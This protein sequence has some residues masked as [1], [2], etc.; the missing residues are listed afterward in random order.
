MRKRLRV[1]ALLLAIPLAMGGVAGVV[2]ARGGDGLA[3]GL[4]ARAKIETSERGA[5][6]ADEALSA[7][8]AGAQILRLPVL[9]FGMLGAA[10]VLAAY[11]LAPAFRGRRRGRTAKKSA[12]PKAAALASAAE[13]DLSAPSAKESKRI[14]KQAAQ[15]EQ[16]QGAEAAGEF[17]LGRNLKEEAIEIFLRAELLGRAAEVRHD[18]NRF[19]EAADLYKKLGKEEHAGRIYAQLGRHEDAAKCY[20]AAG[21]F[22]VAGDMFER[23]GNHREAGKCYQK[24][25][26]HRHAAQAFLKSGADALAAESLLSAF[27]EEGGVAGAKSEQKAKEMRGIAKK[28]A[29]ILVKLERFDEAEAMLVRSEAFGPAAKIAFQTG[30]FKRAAE[31]FLRVGRGDLAAKALERLGD[32]VGAARALGEYLRDKGQEAEAVEHLRK[33]GEHAAAGDLYRKLGR[34][35]EAGVCYRDADDFPAAAEAFRAAEQLEPAAEAY[36]RCGKFAEAAES[37]ARAGRADLQAEMLEKAGDTFTAG[38]L[39]AEQGKADGAIRLMQQIPADSPNYGEACSILG[40]MFQEKGM[41]SL[42]V[43][44]FTEATGS[45]TIA[46]NSVDAF[47]ELGRA[48]E[49]QGDL[50]GAIEI[51][52]RILSF[53]YH[54]KDAAACLERCKGM[55]ARQS[56]DL[57]PLTAPTA[58]APA[59]SRYEIVR[60]LGRGGMGVVYLARDSVLEREVAYKVLPEGLRENPNALKNFLREAK[61]AAALNHPNIV[62]VYDAGESEHGFYMAMERVEGTTLKEILRQRGPVSANAVVY[63]LRQMASALSYAHG[64]KVVHRDI[65]TANTM[66]TA[67][68]HVKIMDFGLAKLMEEVR[69]ATTMISGTPFYMSPEQT[70]GRDVDHRTDIYSLGVTIFE[71]ATGELPFQKG[72]VPYHHVHT[73]P[74]DPR[75]VKADIPVGLSQIILRCLKKAPAERYQTAKELIEDLDRLAKA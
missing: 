21:K 13:T 38:K 36:S 52:E 12:S 56:E 30:N 9:H 7:G 6:S 24:I 18:Q 58:P 15:I 69:N 26:F 17:L 37:Y 44:K 74:P 55:V 70:L 51:F 1:I 10:V 49:R 64:R 65:K 31:L 2:L 35:G 59:T 40:R 72:N 32:A 50:V 22:S 23:A 43:K 66:W 68:R 67:E 71:L 53:D 47:Y 46:R 62:T 25:G 19:D 33:A 5:Q 42:S 41:H 8:L 34:Y 39:Y 61:A 73:P 4:R 29:E 57:P 63:I 60:E 54:Y 28:A 20:F 14:L 16:D 3:A 48:H 27:N 45:Q 75:D 11:A